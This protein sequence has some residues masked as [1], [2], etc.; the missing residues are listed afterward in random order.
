MKVLIT[1][2]Q[3]FIGKNLSAR[4]NENEEYSVL[5][6]TRDDSAY[7]LQDKIIESDAIVHLAGVNRPVNKSEFKTINVGLTELICQLIR[8]E[9]GREIP[10]I[11]AS[12]TQAKLD[13]PYGK[14]KY[15]AE[16]LVELLSLETGNPVALYQLPSVFGRWC[17]PNYN[18][19]VATFCHNIANNLP[20][21]INDSQTQLILVYIDDVITD[22]I[23]LLDNQFK[24][25]SRPIIRPEYSVTLG[26]LARQI[27]G[28]KENRNT[29]FIE[30]I[31][32]DFNS[33]LYSTYLSYLSSDNF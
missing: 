7:D 17:K 14:S 31:D 28:F 24:G 3:G 30:N 18:S 5:P 23:R 2:H 27:E 1:G 15:A 13:N 8:N 29:S 16:V 25:F 22:I 11:V 6:F 19:V 10:L 33:A 12:S 32:K 4:L 20:I 26:D 21:K 9:G